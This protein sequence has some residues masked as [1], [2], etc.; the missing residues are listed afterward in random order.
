GDNTSALFEFAATGRPV[1]VL[2]APWYRQDVDHGLRFWD[3][4]DVG[5]RVGAPGDLAAAVA[6]ALA[7]PPERRAERERVVAAVY[8]RPAGGAAA[9]GGGRGGGP[10]GGPPGGRRGRGGAR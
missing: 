5:V 4:A 6:T 1:V 10:R 2:D 3:A 8:A 7:D 9:A